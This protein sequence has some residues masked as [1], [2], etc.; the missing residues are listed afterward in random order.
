MQ[1]HVLMKIQWFLTVIAGFFW[2]GACWSNHISGYSMIIGLNQVSSWG[3]SLDAYLPFMLSLLFFLVSIAFPIFLLAIQYGI[4][5]K[6]YSLTQF[7]FLLSV[8]LCLFLVGLLLN[9]IAIDSA[10]SWAEVLLFSVSIDSGI[11]LNLSYVFFGA[12]FLFAVSA[13]ILS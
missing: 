9:L 11:I 12:G 8:I 5:Y 10:I 13:L 4:Y 1:R 7:M 2:G 3:V 6:K